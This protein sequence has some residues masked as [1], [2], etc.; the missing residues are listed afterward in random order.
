MRSTAVLIFANSS[1]EE[2]QYKPI[3]H[4]EVLFDALTKQT[5]KKVE[6]TS[7]SYFHITEEQQEGSSFGERFTNA[8]QNVFD[9]GFEKVITIGNDTPHLRSKDIRN[10]AAAL[11]SGKTV[12]GPSL[13]GGFYLMGIH[14][15]NFDP[16]H[17]VNLP[18]QQIGL[19]NALLQNLERKNCTIYNLP[20]RSDIDDFQ[21]IK[22]LSNYI[23]SLPVTIRA[24][25]NVYLRIAN[26]IY[27]FVK[28]FYTTF[29]TELPSNKGSP[30]LFQ[31]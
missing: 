31:V 7:L 28:E 5:L 16:D 1:E 21:D 25:L 27:L 22:T 15:D 12:I 17:F 10:A 9:L 2:L 30:L 26:S 19:Y 18:W 14:R 24:I 3:Q 23:K 13:D 20:V 29:Y 4:G 8:I 6:K 11:I